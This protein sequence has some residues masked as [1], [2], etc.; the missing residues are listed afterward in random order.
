[1][2]QYRYPVR[3][4]Y[5]ELPQGSRDQLAGADPPELARAE[6]REETGLRAATMVH[7]GRL[8]LGFGYSSQAYDVFLATGLRQGERDLDREEQDLVTRAFAL[9]EFEA[10]VREASSWTQP[11]SPRSASSGSGGF[12]EGQRRARPLAPEPIP[13]WP[14]SRA[15]RA[16]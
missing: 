15:C 8:F 14:R 7:A 13:A 1:V 5:W 11:S 9:A 6:L 2:E 12:S 3:G 4:R 16:R 10:M